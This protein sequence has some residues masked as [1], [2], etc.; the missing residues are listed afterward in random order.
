MQMMRS[1]SIELATR[2][3]IESLMKTNFKTSITLFALYNS[4]LNRIIIDPSLMVMPII[5]RQFHFAHSIFD[6]LTCENGIIP[7]LERI[8]LRIK[9]SCDASA[10]PLPMSLEDIKLK[11]SHLAF[12]CISNFNLEKSKFFIKV[13]VSSG[14]SDF[15]L[16]PST[17]S[18]SILY[19]I[20]YYDPNQVVDLSKLYK[21]CSIPSKTIKSGIFAQT[22]SSNYLSNS[23]IAIE[24]KKKGALNGVMLDE[25][26]FI[27]ECPTANVGFVWK[28]SKQFIIPKWEKVLKGSTL[29]ECLAF[30]EKILIPK[31]IISGIK[32]KDIRPSDVYD[33]VEEMIVFGGGKVIGI[34]E[35]DNHYIRN[36]LGPVC[37]SL[38]NYLFEEYRKTAY[39]VD[40]K[41]YEKKKQFPK[42]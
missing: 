32:E 18:R 34:S 29:V 23:M 16:L 17:N 40:M 21:E 41:L 6:S 13:Y 42:L 14:I 22:K 2:N 37:K 38:Q 1:N 3:E 36:N 26:G 7:L 19:I 35:F 24:A 25:E 15:S 30:I 39:K 10:I 9:K 31:G 20:A 11:I 5:D 4:L 27:T 12:F 33:N 8:I 28:K